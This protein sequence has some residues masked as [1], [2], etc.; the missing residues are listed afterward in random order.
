MIGFRYRTDQLVDAGDYLVNDDTG[1][2]WRVL[3]AREVTPKQPTGYRYLWAITGER[4][5]A[6]TTYDTGVEWHHFTRDRRPSL[7]RRRR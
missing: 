5:A 6:P 4:I 2:V 1:N 7:R 3:A